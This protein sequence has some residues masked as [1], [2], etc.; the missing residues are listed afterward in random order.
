[1]NSFAAAGQV[2]QFLSWIGLGSVALIVVV[3]GMDVG[4]VEPLPAI[5]DIPW[6][7]LVGAASLGMVFD[8][9]INIGIAFTFPFFIS[10]GT[11]LGIPANMALDLLVRKAQLSPLQITGAVMVVGSFLLMITPGSI[12]TWKYQSSSHP[13]ASGREAPSV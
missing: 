3:V 7:Y 8:V 12:A 11:I 13:R 5:R 10:L 9:S 4:G 2:T 1:M 6:G